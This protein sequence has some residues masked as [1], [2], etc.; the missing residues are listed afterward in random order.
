MISKY[1]IGIPLQTEQ[2][3]NGNKKHASQ[4]VY[5]TVTGF[6]RPQLFNEMDRTGS[7]IL[8]YTVNQYDVNGLPAQGTQFGSNTSS[9]YVWDKGRLASISV[10]NPNGTGD[11]LTKQYTYNTGTT[12]LQQI[13]DENS[14]KS[15]F[16]YD[17]L[18][19]LNLLHTRFD[20]NNT[21]H[22][23]T[24][25]NYNYGGPNANF[26]K[27]T[28][29]FAD[30]SHTQISDQFVDGLGRP[31]QSI[32][33]NYTPAYLNQKNNITYDALGRQD[34][35]YQV[36]ESNLNTF[37]NAGATPYTY[38]VYEPSPLNRPV[39]HYSETGTATKMA[40]GT[41][42]STDNVQCFTAVL[43]SSTGTEYAST[44]SVAYAANVLYKT[45]SW[46]E[47][48][49]QNNA[50]LKKA[51][52][53]M[54]KDKLGRNVLTR[55]FVKVNGTYQNVDTYYVYDDY[56]NLAMV[57]PP[58]VL[59]PG[60]TIS[61]FSLVFQY[62]YDT[63]NRLACK[64]I[65]GADRV[66]IYY[67]SRDLPVFIQDGNQRGL[68]RFLATK[69]DDYGRA[70]Q[71][72]YIAAINS[73]RYGIETYYTETPGNYLPSDDSQT[74]IKTT[75][76]TNKNR[77]L[78]VSA[79]NLDPAAT[80]ISGDADMITTNNEYDVYGLVSGTDGNSH[81]GK[82]TSLYF[83]TNDFGKPTVNYHSWVGTDNN[84]LVTLQNNSY[85][86]GL[87][88]KDT[89]HQIVL[90]S[91]SNKTVL[92]NVSHLNYD[93]KDRLIEKN[94]GG[95]FSYNTYAY[96]QLQSIDYTYNDRGWLLTMNKGRLSNPVTEKFYPVISAR[97]YYTGN[98]CYSGAYGLN[99][100]PAVQSGDQ[101]PDLFAMELRYDQG[102]TIQGSQVL[103][104]NG[105]IAQM[106]WQTG[107]REAQVY[108]LGY[109]ELDRLTVANYT[110]IN[111]TMCG[112][113]ADPYSTD[114]KYMENISYDLR[115]NIKTL[116]RNGLYY[117]SGTGGSG[118]ALVG[119]FGTIDNLTYNYVNG[120]NQ[121]TN[122]T[123]AM[124]GS[125]AENSITN[126]F[127]QN[128][129]IN[130]T[131]GGYVYDAN[132][133]MVNDYHK[134]IT[135]Q[136]NYLNL[137]QLITFSNGK[138]ITFTYDATGKKWRKTTSD[139]QTFPNVRDYIDGVEYTSNKG[140]PNY[141]TNVSPDI[142]NFG[143]GYIQYD[144]S[145][146]GNS[147]WQG[148]VYK[149]ALK[150]HL[151]NTRVVFSDRD[152]NGVVGVADI[153]QINNYYPFGMNMDGPW[154]GAGGAFKYQ[155]N[156]KEWQGD[157]GLNWNDYGAR[158]YDP[159]I[160]RWTTSDPLAEKM[161]RHS[162]YNYAFDNP[163]RFIDPDGMGPNDVIIL[164]ARPHGGNHPTGHQ[165]IL[166]GDDKNGWKFYS[167]DHATGS[168]VQST[169]SRHSITDINTRKFDNLKDF[170][171]SQFNTYKEN[172]QDGKGTKTSEKD[173]QGNT[174][175]RFSDAYRI[176]SSPG[177]DVIM[178]T[179]AEQNAK[180]PYQ[181]GS[182][183]CTG[184]AKCALDAG[185]LKNGEQEISLSEMI[186]LSLS[187]SGSPSSI[188]DQLGN[189]INNSMPTV[190]FEEIKKRNAGT[191][192]SNDLKPDK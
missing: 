21:A 57:I 31:I 132:G 86:N 35:M 10:K 47:N 12:L 116:Q 67:N 43:N 95:A 74:Y 180:G 178:Q 92:R 126:G 163:I 106:I 182:T 91:W 176:K 56:G 117:T 108:S 140:Y 101:N 23:N 146:T 147:S 118:P 111:S 88:L 27:T 121:I 123:D 190:K 87:R 112:N 73:N 90:G 78:T 17:N 62:I 13:I 63:R 161:R 134:G 3:V 135:I 186:N 44:T 174:L 113:G 81:L 39:M 30:G 142:I 83:P 59:T 183:D 58:D 37:E 167:K 45:T 103:Q 22:V 14:I 104:Y 191:D 152:D 99:H 98:N 165:A 125:A 137:P 175:Q 25:H 131:S 4:T 72:G 124:T 187:Q 79:K 52:T 26:L 77:V 61:D 102:S 153:E 143:E 164:L 85:D 169:P 18:M 2:W 127:K 122:I 129:S 93:A 41:N 155:Y 130:G 100:D 38:T 136:Y 150:D 120:R 105:N 177:N 96:T 181:L 179:A 60:N 97:D 173:A 71:T 133:N 15:T 184:V 110:D 166:I 75:Y 170:S 24:T 65:P 162:P 158:F 156:G 33:E 114:N 109:D 68:G 82:Y 84:Y 51:A 185:G 34:K 70:I 50:D 8:K 160:A 192:V 1:I 80:R 151:G 138:T 107:G 172:Y 19:R 69:Y 32:R 20:A 76:E 89:Y 64:K 139:G 55:K 154:N 149:Y 144:A 11:V 29:T 159:A 157:F 28:T 188:G 94:L 53:E 66:D 54:Y 6:P 16:E 7:M 115:G 145:T 9:F 128:A 40:Y 141:T 36:Y 42:S 49:D 46:N 48:Y 189:S 171:N 119:A 148:W 168:P 5:S